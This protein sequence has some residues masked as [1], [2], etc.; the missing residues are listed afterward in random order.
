MQI[1]PVERSAPQT[2]VRPP[3]VLASAGGFDGDVPDDALLPPARASLTSAPLPANPLAAPRAVVDPRPVIAPP[4]IDAALQ[5]VDTKLQGWLAGASAPPSVQYAVVYNGQIHSRALGMRNLETRE[6]ATAD[7]LY[8]VNSMTKSLTAASIM[9]LVEAGSVKLDEP[10]AT[11]VPEFAAV[12]GADGAAQRITVR[13]LLTHTAGLSRDPALDVWNADNFWDSRAWPSWAQIAERLPQ[14]QVVPN[15]NKEFKYSNLGMAVLGQV[16]SRASG[17][18]Y[19]AYVKQRIFEPLGMSE[20]RFTLSDEEAARTA[21]GYSAARAVNGGPLSRNEAPLLRDLGGLA[22]VSGVRTTARDY[23]RWLQFLADPSRAPGVLAPSSVALMRSSQVFDDSNYAQVGFGLMT[24]PLTPGAPTFGHTG[25]GIGFSSVMRMANDGSVGIV[26]LTNDFNRRMNY[27]ADSMW[28]VLRDLP[29][30]AAA[31]GAAP[32]DPAWQPLIG[33][34]LASSNNVPKVTT[35]ANG[36]LL[37]DGMLLRAIPERPDTFLIAS[38]DRVAQRGETMFFKR[39]A[40][41]NVTHAIVGGTT[42]DRA[43]VV[44]VRQR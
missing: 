7:T 1:N 12:S 27:A 14:A 11:Y 21:V 2:V 37:F 16:V 20:S 23:A 9:Q 17:M 39:D 3:V 6:L 13:Q 32:R 35:N 42:P 15:P 18:P 22:S 4:T 40:E 29:K 30:P 10:V 38:G 43:Q 34:Y 25:S 33:S 28:N 36:D 41:G 19:D 24:T 44:F 5:A 31:P 26:V 8:Q